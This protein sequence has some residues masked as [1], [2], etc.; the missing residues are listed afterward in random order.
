ME[1]NDEQFPNEASICNMQKSYANDVNISKTNPELFDI[2]NRINWQENITLLKDLAT[3][4]P[5]NSIHNFIQGLVE[6]DTADQTE[7]FSLYKL[8]IPRKNPVLNSMANYN[9][10]T[11]FKAFVKSE[12]E[13]LHSLIELLINSNNTEQSAIT[14]I[15]S[16]RLEA[17]ATL[18]QFQTNGFFM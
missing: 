4:A 15:L 7:L 6:L 11:I 9:F 12:T 13:L 18:S 16:R 14:S 3:K 10:Y 17:L 1:F 8:D 5:S 2:L